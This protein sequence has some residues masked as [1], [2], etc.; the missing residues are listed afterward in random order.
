MV[1]QRKRHII[2]DTS[3]L[4]EF[5]AAVPNVIVFVHG[6]FGDS[7]ESWGGTPNQLISS[8]TFGN[9]NCGSYGYGSKYIQLKSPEQFVEQL[10]LWIKVNL[11]HY[12][13]IYFVGHSMGGL[14]VQH[15]LTLMLTRE[16]QRA[17]AAKVRCCFQI[18]SPVS[19]AMLARMGMRIPVISSL[20]GMLNPRLPY[21]ANPNVNGKGLASAY[22]EAATSFVDA[23]GDQ[24]DIPKFYL[25]SGIDDSI[26]SVAAM[27]ARTSFHTYE[28]P[29][30]GSHSSIKQD[31]DPNS[32][33]IQRITQLIQDSLRRSRP[34][35][36]DNIQ[37]IQEL[38]WRREQATEE[39]VDPSAR[40]RGDKRAGGDGLVVIVV[41]CS[42]GKTDANELMHPGAGGIVEQVADSR[43]GTMAVAMRSNILRLVQSGRIEGIEFSQGNRGSKPANQRLVL[44]PDFGGGFNAAKYLPAFARYK[45]RCYQAADQEWQ[46]LLT[47]QNSPE[48]L[49]MSG[50]YGLMPATEHIQN[51]DVHLTDVDTGSGFSLQTFWRDR[52]LMTQVLIS[53][54]DWLEKEKGRVTLIVDALSE[55]SYQETINWSMVHTRWKVLHRVFEK[56]AGIGALDNLGIW[57]RD[58]VQNPANV[59]ALHEDIFYTS[60]HFKA[61]PD[62]RIAFERII[63]I[64]PLQVARETRYQWELSTK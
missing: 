42:N 57:L 13:N 9:F 7:E 17:I 62:D 45:G 51:Y 54:L 31:L 40:T 58:V 5:S 53:H 20:V 16:G 48:F 14:F 35:Q 10:V 12:D 32:V 43:V 25:Y 21:L 56:R 24:A 19:G 23:G 4:D 60:G 52:E 36:S 30:A 37:M 8:P 1:K 33:L 26:V 3:Y 41:S 22:T 29:V 63:G 55:L 28:G 59:Q 61:P 11:A 64:S 34:S 38:V 18:A 2:D 49:I 50:L 44:G 39:K 15:A 27:A 47:R 46:T 6:I